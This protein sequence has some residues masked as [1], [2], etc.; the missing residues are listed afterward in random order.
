MA[1]LHRFAAAVAGALSLTLSAG[2]HAAAGPDPD[3]AW[4]TFKPGAMAPV[5]R[6]LQ[7][8]GARVHHRFG[9]LRAFAATLSPRAQ[10]ALRRRADIESIEPDV[11]RYPMGQVQ[12]YGI[13]MVQAPLVWPTT[14]GGNGVDVCVIDSGIHAAHEDFAGMALDG[15]ASPG[16]SWNTDTCGHGS[17][18]SG[19]IAARS[20]GV[21]VVGVADRRARNVHPGP[22]Q[23]H[24]G[25]RPEAVPG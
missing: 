17:H 5:E 8:A 25:G 12:P 9:D 21:G 16:Q 2:A 20:N 3:R 10:D 18:V 15:Y 7:A 22:G 4:I 11:P 24:P 1:R 14:E 6:A 19:T 13:D 23:R